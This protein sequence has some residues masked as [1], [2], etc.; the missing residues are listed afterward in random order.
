MTEYRL[1]HGRGRRA[2]PC[3]LEKDSPACLTWAGHTKLWQSYGVPENTEGTPPCGVPE[4]RFRDQW[5]QTGQSRLG[6]DLRD[7]R[8]NV[9]LDCDRKNSGGA[10]GLE[11][12]KTEH[13]SQMSARLNRSA[14]CLLRKVQPRVRWVC[15]LTW[16]STRPGVPL[17]YVVGATVRMRCRHPLRNSAPV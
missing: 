15:R 13:G 16:L 3:C 11:T 4:N 7:A 17:F 14:K 6:D 9:K 10:A 5:I 1:D 2:N 8:H 12:K